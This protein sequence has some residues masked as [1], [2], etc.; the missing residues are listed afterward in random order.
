MKDEDIA[1]MKLQFTLIFLFLV[2][3]KVHMDIYSEELIFGV[4]RK[5]NARAYIPGG[6]LN[7]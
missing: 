3:Y 6:L 5:L 2:Q 4:N 1:I 7:W